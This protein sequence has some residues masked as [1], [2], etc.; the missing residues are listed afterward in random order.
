MKMKL[1]KSATIYAI[2]LFLIYN[3]SGQTAISKI[4]DNDSSKN[5]EIKP[6][7]L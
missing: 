5:K 4:A 2:F 7:I 1:C 6:E 3:A